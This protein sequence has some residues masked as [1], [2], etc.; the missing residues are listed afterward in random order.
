MPHR[1]SLQR[2]FWEKMQLL[3]LLNL[4]IAK[5]RTLTV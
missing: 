4:A 5:E 3:S 2:R 1:L